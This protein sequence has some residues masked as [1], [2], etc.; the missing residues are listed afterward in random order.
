MESLKV[1]TSRHCLRR[2]LPYGEG[3]GTHPSLNPW[4]LGRRLLFAFYFITNTQFFLLL[5]YLAW[6]TAGKLGGKDGLLQEAPMPLEAWAPSAVS[7]SHRPGPGNE[8][9]FS[10]RS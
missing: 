2:T 8:G 10:F 6:I 5:F 7:K 1:Q 3:E 4:H 9:I